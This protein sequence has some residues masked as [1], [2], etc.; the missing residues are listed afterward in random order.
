[1]KYNFFDVPKYPNIEDDDFSTVLY[2]KR[3][4]H[5]NKYDENDDNKDKMEY[6]KQKCTGPVR[7]Q[8]HQVFLSN[9]ISP[10]TQYKGIIVYH[11][12][13]T[14]KCVSK[15]TIIQ[16]STQNTIESM[17]NIS[18]GD[19]F[20]YTCGHS[21][22]EHDGKI[23]IPNEQLYTMSYNT[24]TGKK[25]ISKINGIYTEYICNALKYIEL[26]NGTSITCTLT[27][28]VHV[29][30]EWIK[31]MYVNN[32]MSVTTIDGT[33]HVVKCETDKYRGIV[34]DL[35]VNDTHCY[36][37]NNILTHN[38]CAGV[39]IAENFKSL[40][41]KIH[42]V[43]PRS[44]L[45]SEWTRQI[46]KC[47]GNVYKNDKDVHSYYKILTNKSFK[48][49]VLGEKRVMYIDGKKHTE[50]IF[51]SNRIYSLD[52]SL[53]IID[54]AH[55]ISGNEDVDA[56][57]HLVDVSKNLTVIMLSATPMKNKA[58]DIIDLLMVL[59]E[60]KKRIKKELIFKE[61]E[62][63]DDFTE[64][65]EE[66]FKKLIKGRI[67]YL[68]SND[69]LV[70]PGRKDMGELIDGLIFTKVIKC[71]LSPFHIIPK[72]D[73]ILVSYSK[74]MTNFAY[75]GIDNNEIKPFYSRGLD[76]IQRS[77]NDVKLNK[78]LII[79]LFKTMFNDKSI[80]DSFIDATNTSLMGNMY[81]EKYLH[82][83]SSKYLNALKNINNART[84]CLVYTNY[85]V[86]GVDTFKQVLLSNGY[87]EYP[88]T[89]V[90]SD[91]RCYACDDR[92][93]THFNKDHEFK[94]ASFLIVK[95]T[96]TNDGED[97][98]PEK[99]YNDIKNIYNNENNRDGKYIKIL[100]G[101][102]VVNEGIDMRN[103]GEIHIL[104]AHWNLGRDDQVVGRGIR[105][106]SHYDTIK[107]TGI[108]PM[109][110]IYRYASPEDIEMYKQAEQKYL[111]V[112]RVE[113]I[114]KR[115]AI[116]CPYNY[117]RNKISNCNKCRN[118]RS[119]DKTL[120][121]CPRT[122]E[123]EDC[124][125]TC[126]DH[127]LNKLFFDANKYK[128]LSIDELDSSTY[129][130]DL[131]R[132]DIILIQELISKMY[133]ENN[134]YPYHV[135]ENRVKKLYEK[136]NRYYDIH[137]LLRALNK[138]VHRSIADS[139]DKNILYDAYH[140]PGYLIASGDHYIFKPY[141]IETSYNIYNNKPYVSIEETNTKKQE[142][143][144]TYD[145]LSSKKP[146]RYL[147]T[148][149]SKIIDNEKHDILKILDMKYKNDRSTEYGMVCYNSF[150]QE[151]LIEI[152]KSV[153]YKYNTDSNKSMKRVAICKGITLHMLKL[154]YDSRDLRYIRVP[155]NHDTLPYPF[156]IHDRRKY[157]L[158]N[159][160][161]TSLR[162]NI[163]SFAN[164]IS[165]Y[166][167]ILESTKSIIVKNT[168]VLES[169]SDSLKKI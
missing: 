166:K 138:F 5:L 71:N 109:V 9:Y 51:S 30:G 70:Y 37:A 54:E 154:E 94:P 60:K 136:N 105:Y 97:I 87:V 144:Y 74:A 43:V 149:V 140:N 164:D 11:E 104:D 33:Y 86:V 155:K 28:R 110:K 133:E 49:S 19:L 48:K 36:Y 152:S 148:I 50:R 113:H 106:C 145:P 163:I 123:F 75:P 24:S 92:Y 73:D 52:N 150:S 135:I 101:S 134:K 167:D 85:V 17:K 76:G 156:N 2:K 103:V 80:D 142:N 126:D 139:I 10:N 83:F 120:P 89:H 57:K 27:H 22:Y 53:L 107:K 1:M 84:T 18:I 25:V 59:V 141:D 132:A 79:E 153:G 31:S 108:M 65:G 158:N 64:K 121:L 29:N 21:Y 116:D 125:Y 34:Y 38:T 77:I 160:E 6:I 42:I 3:E 118:Y 41:S 45:K 82:M 23:L 162:N 151:I 90:K 61:S 12:T 15:N 129:S 66:I 8:E 122:C 67:S 161:G 102:K 91:T 7:L 169:L 44:L 146:A 35:S 13:G 147:G 56:V 39:S 93:T 88:N 131:S 98:V 100:V 68:K 69:P 55:N 40:S 114:V 14:G 4:Y 46:I 32:G 81:N 165:K 78:P 130:Y 137:F 72:S 47:T 16:Y 115:N 58:S 26:S 96:S 62:L 63:M 157:I 168:I 20:R 117:M 128:T 159:I 111:F 143:S 95:A 124:N 119:D 99:L 112:K 127:N